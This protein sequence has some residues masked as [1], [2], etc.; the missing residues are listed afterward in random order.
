M[1][2]IRINVIAARLSDKGI[3]YHYQGSQVIRCVWSDHYNATIEEPMH[4]D[5][6]DNI[7]A[8]IARDAELVL[9]P[10]EQLAAKYDHDLG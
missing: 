7:N 2:T 1:K 6:D 8:A 4:Y 3:S 10:G 9:K 5:Y